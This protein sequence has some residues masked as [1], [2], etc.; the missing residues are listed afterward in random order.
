M[1]ARGSASPREAMA[2]GAWS[3]IGSAVGT[4]AALLLLAWLLGRDESSTG[5]RYGM[6]VQ[7]A[8]VATD[9]EC[10]GAWL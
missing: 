7:A 10:E 8:S 9:P 5:T 1:A 3:G 2:W 6:S 4:A